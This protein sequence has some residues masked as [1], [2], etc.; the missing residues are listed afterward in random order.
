MH[1]AQWIHST[2]SQVVL[3]QWRSLPP[4]T[5]VEKLL[6]ETSWHQFHFTQRRTAPLVQMMKIAL[7]VIVMQWFTKCTM[8]PWMQTCLQMYKIYLSPFDTGSVEQWLKFLAK[9]NLIITGNGLMAGPAKF[10]LMQSLLKGEAL[11]HSNNKAKELGNKTNTHHKQC[12]NASHGLCTHFPPRMLFRCRNITCERSISA[13][14]WPLVSTLHIGINKMT[15][16]PSMWTWC[17]FARSLN[18]LNS[19]IN[20]KRNWRPKR[21]TQKKTMVS[22]LER[23]MPILLTNHHLYLPRSHVCFMV[24]ALTPQMN[25]RWWRNKQKGWKQ[26]IRC[27]LPLSAPRNARNGRPRRLPL[28]TK[29]TKWWMKVSRS[30]WRKSHMKTL[31]KCSHEDTNSNSDLEHEHY[32]MEEISLDF[33]GIIN[34]SE[35]F[36]LSHMCRPPQKCQKTNH[37]TPVTIAL[38]NTQLGKSRFNK[39]RI[40]LDSRSSRSIILNKFVN[41]IWMQNDTTSWIMKGGNFQTSKKCKTTF[42]LKEFFKSKSIEWNLHV[43]STPGPH[44]YD[45]ILGH[46]II[47]ELRIMLNFKDQT[48]NW[49]DSTIHMKVPESLP[50]LLDPVNDFFWNN[51]HYETEVLQEA[52]ICLQKI[53]DAKCALADLDVVVQACRHLTED[54]KHQLHALLCK[55]EHLFDGTLGTWNNDPYNIK[56]KE[57]AKPYHSR[58]FPIPKIHEHTLK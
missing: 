51:D 19:P 41:K 58:P 54:E 52:S 37:L 13:V 3:W 29:L 44:C 32:C 17:S 50:D 39:I 34:V 53:L 21:K 30:L 56:L 55:Y 10:N 22:V 18:V 16:L 46:D 8:T 4:M 48:M 31:K 26:C 35:T 1:S 49:V 40:L 38:I 25:V 20:W 24:L 23:S 45:M 11:W 47:S 36:A 2:S 28:M 43:D 15:T 9:L 33:E 57:G 6:P 14:W 7:N 27:K 42:I 5:M 12:L